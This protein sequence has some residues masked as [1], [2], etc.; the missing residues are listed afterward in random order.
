MSEPSEKRHILHL[1]VDGF[2]VAQ[3]VELSQSAPGTDAVTE[4]FHLT[5]LNAREAL[6]KIFATDTVAVWC[7]ID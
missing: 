3:L 4:I 1:V 2:P 6:E 7:R 5:E